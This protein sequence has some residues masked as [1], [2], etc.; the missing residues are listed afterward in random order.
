MELA[1]NDL[2]DDCVKKPSEMRALADDAA[3]YSNT[4]L[5]MIMMKSFA[6]WGCVIEVEIQA[7]QRKSWRGWRGLSFSV[8]RDEHMK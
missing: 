5:L 7:Q 4:T 2:H 6:E 8:N 1:S 3:R